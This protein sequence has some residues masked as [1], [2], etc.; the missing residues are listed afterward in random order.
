M[1]HLVFKIISFHKPL[2]KKAW[3]QFQDILCVVVAKAVVNQKSLIAK[4][5][6]NTSN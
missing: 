1:N 3:R 6:Q 2:L 5:L 4:I